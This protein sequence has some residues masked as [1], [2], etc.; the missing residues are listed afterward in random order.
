[1]ASLAEVAALLQRGEAARALGLLEGLRRSHPGVPDV[2]HLSAQA[3]A[4]LGRFA[5]AL[6]WAQQALRLAP[7]RAPYAHTLGLLYLRLS[8]PAEALAAADHGIG[9]AP[10]DPSLK[11]LRGRALLAQGRPAEALPLLDGAFAVEALLALGRPQEALSRLAALPPSAG[12]F[13]QEGAAYAQLQEPALAETAFAEALAREPGRLDWRRAAARAASLAW[14]LDAAQARWRALL[15]ELPDDVEAT[16]GL[17]SALHRDGEDAAAWSLIEGPLREGRADLSMRLV[18]VPLVIGRPEAE[19][20]E[21][22]LRQDL[23]AGADPIAVWGAIGRLREAAAD[24]DGA[25]AAHAASNAARAQR[26]DVARS[27]AQIAGLKALWP[28][29]QPLRRATVGEGPR[30][31]FVVGNPRSGSSLLEQILSC[32]PAVHAAGERMALH[33]LA[34]SRPG[35]FPDGWA[36]ADE[37]TLQTAADAYRAEL[38][39]LRG[40]RPIVTDKLP[41]NYLYIGLIAQLFP[42]AQI[43][44]CRRDP[45]DTALSI[46]FLRFGPH[47]P[48]CSTLAGLGA[49]LR[50]AEDLRQHWEAAGILP[51]LTVDHE[52][53]VRDL[54]GQTRRICAAL[55]LEWSPALLRPEQSARR[56]TTASYAQVRQPVS[57]RGLLRSRA[58]RAHLQPLLDALGDLCPADLR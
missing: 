57:D 52:A 25:F 27:A 8:R 22:D 31:V 53:L 9:R 20:V 26:Y 46:F 3:C 58:Y 40:G 10:D 6:P 15:V 24:V 23:V 54:E 36:G 11:S 56:V 16:A 14:R 49:A 13:A 38:A 28:V 12:R 41:Q 51:M 37:A 1:M 18:A 19:R 17:A 42:D 33:R 43:L 2:W 50:H 55:G 35:G 44:W 21:S 32:H 48:V 45:V 30:P 39:Q 34:W 5:E 29:G 4:R 47:V 7:A